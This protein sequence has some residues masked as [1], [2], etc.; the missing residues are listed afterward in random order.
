MYESI[1]LA[2]ANTYLAPLE[3]LIER[4]ASYYLALSERDAFTMPDDEA[5]R[6]HR[7]MQELAAEVELLD[8]LLHSIEDIRDTYSARLIAAENA[9]A[10]AAR[11]HTAL[12][13]SH[14]MLFEANQSDYEYQTLLHKIILSR[15][16][17]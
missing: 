11:E 3:K 5:R 6:H 16:A 13:K 10:A 4:K 9:L 14:A 17:A 12:L 1:Q 7:R 15:R 2:I 8:N